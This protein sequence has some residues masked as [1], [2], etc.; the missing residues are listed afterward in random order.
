MVKFDSKTHITIDNTLENKDEAT[1]YIK[2]LESESLRH[3]EDIIEIQ[4]RITKIQTEWGI[5]R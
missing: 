2:F 3:A 1:A 4:K 5:K